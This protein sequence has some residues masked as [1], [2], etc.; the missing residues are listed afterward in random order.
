MPTSDYQNWKGERLPS[1]TQILDQ[2]WPK[3]GLIEWANREGLAGRSHTVVRDRLARVGTL[4]HALVFA[5]MGGPAVG[6]KEEGAYSE[7][8]RQAARIPYFHA[9]TWF[10][11]LGAL[12]GENA[13]FVE[14]PMIHARF[15]F[16]GTPDWY[17]ILDIDNGGPKYTVLDLK[18]GRQ[19]VEHGVQLA[20]YAELLRA[21]GHVVE[22]AVALYA[23]RTI[24]GTANHTRWRGEGLKAIT[25]AWAAVLQLYRMRTIIG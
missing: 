16:G 12:G 22:Q 9:R 6:E 11:S 19:F 21:N 3:P 2:T 23:P 13:L 24:R 15:G 1:V 25:E 5:E 20:A 14:Q 10:E 8:T 17:G 7:E 18:T 4:A